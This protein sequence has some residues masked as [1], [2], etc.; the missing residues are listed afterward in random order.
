MTE[1]GVGLM[2]QPSWSCAC[3]TSLSLSALIR[4][5]LLTLDTIG[6]GDFLICAI[7]LVTKE[8]RGQEPFVGRRAILPCVVLT[9]HTC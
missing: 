3:G 6:L 9:I 7:F 4:W 1:A 8:G 2:P 5:A